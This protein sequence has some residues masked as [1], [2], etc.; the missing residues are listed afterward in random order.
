M[1]LEQIVHTFNLIVSRLAN[2]EDP[3]FEM[4][5]VWIGF[6]NGDVTQSTY[7]LVDHTHGAIFWADQIKCHDIGLP[8]VENLGHL[9]AYTI[10]RTSTVSD[11]AL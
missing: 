3:H 7:Y 10:P 8:G 2:A 4:V 5:E 1:K 11:A 9:S 6:L